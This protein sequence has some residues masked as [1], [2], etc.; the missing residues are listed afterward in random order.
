MPNITRHPALHRIRKE[1]DT[2]LKSSLI[3]CIMVVLTLP[4]YAAQT[5]FSLH[6]DRGTVQPGVDI[7]TQD[8]TEE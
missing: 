6:N 7:D 1:F 2:F 3:F 8:I 5:L 4:A